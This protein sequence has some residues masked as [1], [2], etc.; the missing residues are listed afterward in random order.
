MWDLYK[1]WASPRKKLTKLAYETSL[2]DYSIPLFKVPGVSGA[3]IPLEA[4]HVRGMNFRFTILT[5]AVLLCLLSM[6]TAGG[7]SPSSEAI[8]NWLIGV[9]AA[10]VI[11]GTCCACSCALMK[12]KDTVYSRPFADSEPYTPPNQPVPHE[13]PICNDLVAAVGFMEGVV[14]MMEVVVEGVNLA[15][16]CDD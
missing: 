15:I 4:I 12:E 11:V 3:L 1:R 8:V 2:L 5:F 6:S 13:A 7:G 14:G 10:I 9:T 16:E